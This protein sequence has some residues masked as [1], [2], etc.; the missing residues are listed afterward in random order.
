MEQQQLKHKEDL[1]RLKQVYEE[2]LKIVEKEAE[3]R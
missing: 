3:E 2:K 1:V